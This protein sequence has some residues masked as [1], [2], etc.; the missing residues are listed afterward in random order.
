NSPSRL[1]LNKDLGPAFY[2]STIL[3]NSSQHILMVS[4][5]AIR[6]PPSQKHPSREN[7]SQEYFPHNLPIQQSFDP[8]KLPKTLS[9]FEHVPSYSAARVQTMFIAVENR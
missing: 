6:K 4:L 5:R 7:I 8:S 2:S 9:V 1:S 3:H